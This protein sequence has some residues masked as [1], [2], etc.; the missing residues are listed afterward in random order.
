MTIRLH[1]T[2]APAPRSR[3]DRAVGG[4]GVYLA[5]AIGEVIVQLDEAHWLRCVLFC[6]VLAI[7]TF[8]WHVVQAVRGRP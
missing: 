1:F 2:A 6:V 5:M 4:A 3:M 7:A 8:V